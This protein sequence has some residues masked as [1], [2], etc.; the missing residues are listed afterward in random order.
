MR[1]KFAGNLLLLIFANLLVKPFWI[2]GIDR[3]VQNKVGPAE[4][5]TYFA[6]FNFSFLFGI[7]LDFGLNNFNNRAIARHPSRLAS[8]FPNLMVVKFALSLLYFLVAFIAAGLTG[9]SALQIKMLAALALNQVLLSYILYLRSNLTALHLFKVD[10]VI[11][12]M[13]RLLAIIFCSFFLYSGVWTDGYF[14]IDYFIYS[15][16]AALFI[17]GVIAFIFLR[18]RRGFKLDLWRWRFVRAILLRSA[19]FALLGLLMTIYYRI[20]AIMLERMYSAVET[21]IYAKSYRLLDAV[22]QF[23]YLF[24]VP[25]LPLFAG[26]IRR[27]ENIEELLSFSAVIMFLFA[28][29]TAILCA[30]FGTEIMTLLYH[31]SDPYSIRIFSLL[32]ISFIPISSVYIFGT[33]LTAHG[34]MK[35][36]NLIAIGGIVI[37]VGL[38]LI[39]IP[40]Y[41]AL[42]TTLATLF[43]QF[44]VALLH[45]IAVNTS[46]QIKW[47]WGL[48]VR[49]VTYIVLAI[50]LSL[51]LT[52]IPM[53]W[54][55]RIVINATLL[56]A[57]ILLL[58]LVPLSMLKRLRGVAN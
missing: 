4:Y 12:V 46:F 35:V 56:G 41:G 43:T 44:V 20:D 40:T 29:S 17:T 45:I 58:Q 57:L 1:K 26:M 39:M 2:F 31:R 42:G 30:F 6:L 24:G 23:G 16:T 48:I 53:H 5:G 11:S 32:M 51:A 8:Y 22:N 10:S 18:G 15:Q 27:R 55:G 33:L 50:A 3:V 34:S 25:L 49:L 21:G 9:Y 19:P 14:D 54:M 37:N 38:N 52:Y 7:V 36:L 47:K 13:D 28:A